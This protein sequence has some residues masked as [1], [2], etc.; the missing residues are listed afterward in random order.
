MF[1]VRNLACPFTALSEM[2]T[3]HSTYSIL[4]SY[5]V[6]QKYWLHKYSTSQAVQWVSEADHSCVCGVMIWQ[7]LTC[8]PTAYTQTSLHTSHYKSVSFYY[9][10][11]AAK[12]QQSIQA[13]NSCITH[14]SNNLFYLSS[15]PYFFLHSRGGS[16]S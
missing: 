7:P 14:L 15:S 11:A 5:T 6:L 13:Q 8:Y 9:T 16:V 1:T 10:D 3:H 2:Y 12:Y 4:Y